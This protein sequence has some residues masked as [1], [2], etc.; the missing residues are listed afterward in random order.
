MSKKLTEIE[1][2]S[3][4]QEDRINE[5]LANNKEVMKLIRDLS[6]QMADDKLESNKNYWSL[7]VKVTAISTILTF[8]GRKFFLIGM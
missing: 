5:I 2:R 6:K 8:L 7:V 1:T 4:Y 3:K